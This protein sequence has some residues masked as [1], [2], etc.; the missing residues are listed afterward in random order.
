MHQLW[1]RFNSAKVAGAKQEAAQLHSLALSVPLSCCYY[2]LPLEEIRYIPV[3]Q[4]ALAIR[5]TGP[6]LMLHSW[7]WGVDHGADEACCRLALLP[8][9]L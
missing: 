8:S 3:A 1:K 6:E 5:Q 4:H 9:A 2:Q 7:P